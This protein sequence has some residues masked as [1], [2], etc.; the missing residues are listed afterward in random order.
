LIHINE[1]GG[2]Q[3]YRRGE[4]Q[5]DVMSETSSALP[6][7]DTAQQALEMAQRGLGA[8]ADVQRELSA[9]CEQTG[10]TW[11]QRLQEEFNFCS[12]AMAGFAAARSGPEFL[13]AYSQCLGQRFRMA[14]EDA[15]HLFQDWL[16]V[17]QAFTRPFLGGR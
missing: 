6:Q 4:R 3:V 8:A 12:D 11:A 14:A 7:A 13:N 5:E 16:D 17:S 9:V 15:Q 1:R 10:K 2:D